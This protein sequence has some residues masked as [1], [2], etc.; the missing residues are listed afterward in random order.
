MTPETWER[1]KA[2]FDAA[3]Q[4]SPSEREN[5]LNTA[6]GGDASLRAEVESLLAA[7]ETESFLDTF[8]SQTRSQL[9][10]ALADR[11]RLERELGR[12]GMATVYLAHDLRHDRP[13]ALKVL[14]PEL[15]SALGPERFL[16]EIK[17]AA[18]LQ[19]PHILSVHDSGESAGYIWFTMPLVEGESLRDR[20]NREKQLPVEDALRIAGE[21]AEALDC[22]HRHGVVHR[23]V[24]PE[25]ILL[26]ESHALVADFG[27]ARA[28]GGSEQPL[29]GTGV[30]IGTPAYMSPEQAS[31]TRDIDARTDVYALGCVLF[32]MLAGEPPYTGPTPQAIIA[33]ALTET[34]RPIHPMRTG[35]SPELDAV[36]AKAMAVTP[37]DRYGTAVDFAKALGPGGKLTRGEIRELP[38]FRA[39]IRRPLFAMLAFGFLLGA[40][41]LFAWRWSQLED[42]GGKF[43]AVLPF[44]NLGAPED[45]YIPD[46]IT[47]EVRGRLIAL[48]GVQVIARGSSTPYKKTTKTPQQV[49]Q[50]LGVHYLLTATVRWGKAPGGVR[51]L[52]VSAELV[53]A[54][55]GG[56]PRIKWQDVF[57]ASVTEESLAG[58]FQ[59][60]ADI[61]SRVA[62]ALGIVLEDSVRQQ[63]AEPRT[64]NLT[65]YDAYLQGE[66]VSQSLA[67]GDPAT[68]RRAAA[69]YA[70]AVALDT[71]FVQA[72][73]QLSR[74]HS[75]L[76]LNSTPTPT[77]AEQARRAAER[78][79]AL[80]PNRAEGHLAMGYYYQ[81][82][83][84]NTARAVEE[85]G[86]G[87]KIAPNDPDLLNYSALT[88]LALGRWEAALA[89]LQRAHT[90]DPRSVLTGFNLAQVLLW[91]RR[92]PEARGAAD[93]ALTLAPTDLGGIELKAMIAL[94]QGNLM[95]A[96]ADVAAALKEVDPAALVAAFAWYWDLN[97]V[98]E[99]A[100][101]ALLLGLPPSAYDNDR[102]N[103]GSVLAQTYWLQ[104]DQPRARAYADSARIAF[105]AHL[106]AAPHDAQQHVFLGLSL[107]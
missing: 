107:S 105:Q 11:Y 56:A 74:V 89:N 50:E 33:R 75:L 53:E 14:H 66:E 17:L 76:Y 26:T 22:A 41:A 2:V 51:N 16:R 68:L 12:G 20:L 62:Q 4:R 24:K 69:Y 81:I 48:P 80:A 58:V 10:T 8:D 25:N 67:A 78:A 28:V 88:D 61:G 77:E 39:L 5:F 9:R 6:C 40:G 19:H 15:A 7:D 27:I 21:V 49:A 34:P 94:A 101:Q 65:A 3:R 91:L 90:L 23:D 35:V 29:T 85:F 92:Y 72:W 38:V 97:W 73:A 70:Q 102:A 79:L 87:L 52:H 100:Q 104:G 18:R 60:Y 99:D 45:E 82:V 44:E 95:Q 63:L 36:I 42:E 93:R 47:D 1:V 86:Q 55:S 31:G 106:R 32:E 54:R 64:Q 57:E 43:L 30:A 71:G 37:A 83:I 13:V 59:V 46:G 103:W 98:L 96:R 84:K